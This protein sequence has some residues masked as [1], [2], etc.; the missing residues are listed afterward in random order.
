MGHDLLNNLFTITMAVYTDDQYQLHI[1]LDNI[2]K[3]LETVYEGAITKSWMVFSSP[4]VLIK[5]RVETSA[6][7]VLKGVLQQPP[8]RNRIRIEVSATDSK[9]LLDIVKEVLKSVEGFPVV[10]EE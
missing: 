4:G 5:V 9:A 8:L 3:A 6:E 7:P 1:V 10:L 2:R